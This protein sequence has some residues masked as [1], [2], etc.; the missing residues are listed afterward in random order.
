M[1]TSLEADKKNIL[2]LIEKIRPYISK[3]KEHK[4]KIPA[5]ENGLIISQLFRFVSP[6]DKIEKF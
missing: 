6:N 5:F 3:A 2:K 1:R 4:E